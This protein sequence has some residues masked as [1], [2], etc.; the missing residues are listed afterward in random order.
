MSINNVKTWQFTVFLG[1]VTMW[2]IVE[3]K[4]RD[5]NKALHIYINRTGIYWP[6]P[7]LPLYTSW[8]GRSDCTTYECLH[9]VFILNHKVFHRISKEPYLC[10]MFVWTLQPLCGS[11]T[12]C[13]SSTERYPSFAR[14]QWACAPSARETGHSP[15]PIPG[16]PTDRPPFGRWGREIGLWSPQSLRACSERTQR[17]AAIQPAELPWSQPA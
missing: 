8:R 9:T 13:P 16:L 1:N 4:S 11:A 5:Y 7:L 10:S 6:A 14:L 2:D 12:H 3:G 15:V 17:A